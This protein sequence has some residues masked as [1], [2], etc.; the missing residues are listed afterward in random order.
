M[1]ASFHREMSGN[2]PPVQTYFSSLPLHPF[3]DSWQSPAEAMSSSQ[4]S[5]DEPNYFSLAAEETACDQICQAA[6][7]TGVTC[8]IVRNIPCRCTAGEVR[9]LLEELGFAESDVKLIHLPW[10]HSQKCNPGYCFIAFHSPSSAL[11]FRNL[12]TGFQFKKRSSKKRLVVEPSREQ[13]MPVSQPICSSDNATSREEVPLT[14]APST[15]TNSENLVYRQQ[16]FPAERRS[17]GKPSI[18]RFSC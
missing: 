3:P 7:W 6:S 2:Q 9:E 11:V 14:F 16:R 5:Y 10:R 12:A 13:T 15:T 8:V 4:R 18:I 1:A 17:P